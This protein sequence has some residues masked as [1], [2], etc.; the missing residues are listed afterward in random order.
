M[1]TVHEYFFPETGTLEI[2]LPLDAQPLHGDK[3]GNDWCLWVLLDPTQEIVT[4]RFVIHGTGRGI[5]RD[6]ESMRHISTFLDGPF[7]WHMFEYL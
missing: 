1:N 6:P 2:G 5:L 7:V 3:Q 4:R